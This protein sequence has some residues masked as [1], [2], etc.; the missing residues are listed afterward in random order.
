MAIAYII[1]IR[2]RCYLSLVCTFEKATKNLDVKVDVRKGA[3]GFRGN[4]NNEG[5]SFIQ[6]TFSSIIII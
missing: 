4:T 6:F 5:A 1:Y 2:V 3:L